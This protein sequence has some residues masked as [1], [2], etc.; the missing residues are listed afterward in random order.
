MSRKNHNHKISFAYLGYGDPATN[1]MKYPV[2]LMETVQRITLEDKNEEAGKL[3]T[4]KRKK[5][6]SGYM[7]KLGFE[8]IAA[9]IAELTPERKKRV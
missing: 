7:M 3:L 6:L 4:D 9:T 1:D 5:K 8:D 2:L